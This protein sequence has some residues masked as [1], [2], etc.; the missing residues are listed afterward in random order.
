METDEGSLSIGTGSEVPDQI[1]LPYPDGGTV[2]SSF[3]VDE[4]ASVTINYPNDQF[5]EIEAF[6]DDMVANSNEAGWQVTEQTLQQPDGVTMRTRS[7]YATEGV[8]QV[9]MRDCYSFDSDFEGPFDQVCVD[10]LEAGD[11]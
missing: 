5:E 9:S 4:Q 8:R 2:M 11:V 3:A 6:Y 7:W 1:T 10:L